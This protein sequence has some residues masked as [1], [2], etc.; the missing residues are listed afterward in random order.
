LSN[1]ASIAYYIKEYVPLLDSTNMTYDN[2]I[3]IALDIKVIFSKFELNL[4][5]NDA[6]FCF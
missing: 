2:Y 5:E 6:V 1:K 3:Q 4:I